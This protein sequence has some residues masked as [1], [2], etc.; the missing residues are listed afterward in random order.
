MTKVNIWEMDRFM[1]S[2]LDEVKTFD[3]LQ[4][5]EDFCTEYNSHNN[6]PYVPEWYM[7]AIIQD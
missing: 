3:T 1:G 2:K 5:A 6:L 4:Q 7:V